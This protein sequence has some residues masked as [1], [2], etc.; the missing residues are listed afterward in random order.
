MYL[1]KFP[2][3]F[4]WYLINMNTPF[5]KEEGF[6]SLVFRKGRISQLYKTM[7]QEKYSN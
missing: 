1:E 3:V 5:R 7:V 6:Q 4:G 2:I